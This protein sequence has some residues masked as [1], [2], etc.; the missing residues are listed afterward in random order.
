MGSWFARLGAAAAAR[1]ATPLKP[2]GLG[3]WLA[4]GFY[5]FGI[6]V[7]ALIVRG[8]RLP[9]NLASSTI[10]WGGVIGAYVRSK[11]GRSGWAGFGYGMAIGW[12]LVFT[13]VS[14]GVMLR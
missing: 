1:A 4:I 13:V 8:G 5:V 7:L 14:V 3:P 12:S 10:F 6:V 2:L 11:Q 9:P